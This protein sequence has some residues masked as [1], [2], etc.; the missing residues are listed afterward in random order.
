MPRNFFSRAK[1]VKVKDHT[2]AGTSDVTSDIIDTAGFDSVVF[3]T[4]VS[5]ANATN[6]FK[7]QQNTANQTTG[8]ADL[9]GS[10]V[11]SGTSDEDLLIEVAKPQE[12]YLQVVVSRGASTTCESIWAILYH[13]QTNL[14][15]NIVSGTSIA[16]QSQVPDEGTA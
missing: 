10:S 1:P 3:L 11:S 16:E 2:A 15:A 14:A 9:A 8:M 13:G 12:R 6:S 5:T 4:S 7:V